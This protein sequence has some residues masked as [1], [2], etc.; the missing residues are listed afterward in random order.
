LDYY[1][2]LMS[3]RLVQEIAEAVTRI[4][5]KTFKQWERESGADRQSAVELFFPQLNSAQ[6][7]ATPP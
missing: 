5:A 7:G 4:S 6:V 3:P 2:A 1:I